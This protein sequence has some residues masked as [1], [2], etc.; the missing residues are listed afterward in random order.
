MA[1][2]IAIIY[3]TSE[4]QTK[5]IADH[6]AQKLERRGPVVDVLDGKKLGDDFDLSAYSAALIGASIHA[7]RFPGYIGDLIEDHQSVLQMLPTAFFSVSLL[8]MFDTGAEGPTVTERVIDEFLEDCEWEPTVRA[9][10]AGAV[11]FTEYGFFKRWMMKFF[12]KRQLDE[13]IDTSKDY[14]YT[15]WKAVDD[16]VEYF[17]SK[18]SIIVEAE[19]GVRPR[20]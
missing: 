14:E 2:R 5:K 17:E 1:E 7:G 4:G 13:S 16:F 9:S 20:G 3:G 18:R 15:D 6:V 19:E 10:F 11:P 8:S 12:L